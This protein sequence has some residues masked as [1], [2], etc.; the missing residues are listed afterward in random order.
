MEDDNKK[1]L[2]SQLMDHLENRSE[3]P[4]FWTECE[5]MIIDPLKK[6]FS[7][8]LIERAIGIVSTNSLEIAHSHELRGVYPIVSLISHNCIRNVSLKFDGE[9]IRCRANVDIE[10]DEQC[11]D[12]NVFAKP[13]L[14]TIRTWKIKKM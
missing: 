4:D 6:H 11:Y 12:L 3:Y 14:E 10:E 9:R 13:E 7:I 1:R 5:K 2:T 8:E